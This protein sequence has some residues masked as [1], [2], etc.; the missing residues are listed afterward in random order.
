M[1][2]KGGLHWMA[3][4]PFLKFRARRTDSF[5]RKRDPLRKK[6]QTKRFL[7]YK[8]DYKVCRP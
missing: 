6:W 8:F 7:Y 4:Y 3:L 2:A 5:Q 1:G